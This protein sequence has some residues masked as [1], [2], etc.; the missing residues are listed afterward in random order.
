M[1]LEFEINDEF[2]FLFLEWCDCKEMRVLFC[3]DFVYLEGEGYS[4]VRCCMCSYG[5]FKC[6]SLYVFT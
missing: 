2:F 6:F 5:L 3:G 1:G 4:E